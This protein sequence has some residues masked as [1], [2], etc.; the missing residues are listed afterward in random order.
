MQM[1][2]WKETI[3]KLYVLLTLVF[4]GLSIYFSFITWGWVFA[5]VVPVIVAILMAILGYF[6]FEH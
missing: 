4:V 6:I 5:I 1:V 2:E 3:E